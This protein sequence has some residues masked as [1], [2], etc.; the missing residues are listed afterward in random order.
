MDLRKAINF[1]RNE[2]LSYQLPNDKQYFDDKKGKVLD[3]LENDI[4]ENRFRRTIEIEVRASN[5]EVIDEMAKD[6][7]EMNGRRF[8]KGKICIK[9]LDI[10]YE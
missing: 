5:M 9:K 8:N 10:T 6:I 1:I 7:E 3:F 2:C 4:A